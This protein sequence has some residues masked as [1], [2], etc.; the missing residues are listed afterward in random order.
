MSFGFSNES[1]KR[2]FKID[3][4][5]FHGLENKKKKILYLV[6]GILNACFGF[7]RVF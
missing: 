3:P 1:Q 2:S 7:L 6:L 4:E 5:P